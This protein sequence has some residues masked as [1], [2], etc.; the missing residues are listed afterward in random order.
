MSQ[1]TE[2]RGNTEKYEYTPARLFKFLNF[3]TEV[4]AEECKHNQSPEEG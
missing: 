2:W 4:E 3:R 1:K